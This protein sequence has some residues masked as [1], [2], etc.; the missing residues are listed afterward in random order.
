[1]G[2]QYCCFCIYKRTAHN[3]QVVF[4]VQLWWYIIP[5]HIAHSDV[6]CVTCK[7]DT[8]PCV[9]CSREVGLH[10]MALEKNKGLTYEY[11]SVV[12]PCRYV[13]L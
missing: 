13:Q 3:K 1:M 8:D 7:L 6:A 12:K 11:R 10:I 4:P 5:S 9:I 2:A